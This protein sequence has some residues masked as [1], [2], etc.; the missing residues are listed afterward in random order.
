[1]T[2]FKHIE[3]ENYTSKD[4]PA[5]SSMAGLGS[6]KITFYITRDIKFRNAE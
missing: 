3:D 5:S 4:F 1:M 2:D 6:Q